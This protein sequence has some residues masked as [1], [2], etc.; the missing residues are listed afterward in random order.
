M[1]TST[2]LLGQQGSRLRLFT[3]WQP[4]T[5]SLG[6]LSARGP[7]LFAHPVRCGTGIQ[8]TRGGDRG[9]TVLARE[10]KTRGKRLRGPRAHSAGP[11]EKR[12]EERDREDRGL[13]VLAREKKDT[14]KEMAGTEGSQCWPG[15]KKTRGKGWRGPRAHSAGPGEKRHEERDGGDRGLTVLAREKLGALKHVTSTRNDRWSRGDWRGTTARGTV[16]LEA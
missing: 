6:K 2:V 7:E 8:K 16:K 3:A 1:L 10:K 13:T 5:G 9:L 15:R 11:G 14:R 12:H 4:T